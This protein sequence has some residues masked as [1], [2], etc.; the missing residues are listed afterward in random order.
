MPYTVTQPTLRPHLS[1]N[2]LQVFATCQK[3]YEYQYIIGDYDDSANI[4]AVAGSAFHEAVA[5]IDTDQQVKADPERLE[6]KLL[7]E[8]LM[9][10]GEALIEY[11]SADIEVQTF[12][13]RNPEWFRSVGLPGI[14]E[15]YVRIRQEEVEAGWTLLDDFS[16]VEC[17]ATFGGVEVLGFIDQILE[18]PE[19]R[20][21]VRDLKT[22]KPKDSHAA[23]LQLYRHIAP[24][25]TDYG[26]LLYVPPG[27]KSVRKV[28]RYDLEPGEIV[29]MLE[30][31]QHAI[32]SESY[33]P[34]GI[35]NGACGQCQHATVCPFAPTR[36]PSRN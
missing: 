33:F 29:S 32:G 23:Q 12:G 7:L 26:Q 8:S 16:E 9:R 18:D 30:A 25:E 15:R 21:V 10:F 34:T 35:F 5:K 4:Y 1:F 19:G 24:M 28:V 14:A 27:Q 17:H 13:N 22:G 36:A 31:M 20:L 3:Q 2:Q 6:Q 11:Q